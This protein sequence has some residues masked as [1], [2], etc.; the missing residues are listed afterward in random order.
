[1]VSLQTVLI[2]RRLVSNQ[3][4]EEYNSDGT[5][6]HDGILAQFSM[7]RP[8]KLHVKKQLFN[9]KRLNNSSHRDEE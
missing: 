6:D 9:E 2:K 4:A 7:A 8:G 5:S 3:C 1:M